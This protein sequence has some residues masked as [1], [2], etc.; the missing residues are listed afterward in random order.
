M[1]LMSTVKSYRASNGE[2]SICPVILRSPDPIGTTKNLR[3]PH[4]A[5]MERP[6]F[7]TPLRCVRNDTTTDEN[8]ICHSESAFGGRRVWGAAS[9]RCFVG[10]RSLEADEFNH[11][12]SMTNPTQTL[13]FRTMT[14]H[15]GISRTPR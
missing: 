1:A 7:L 13:I 15:K 4:L 14:I 6:R 5:R 9:P 10:G 3:P 12:L 2:L 11:L 8:T